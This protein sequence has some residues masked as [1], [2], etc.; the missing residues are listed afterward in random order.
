M[1]NDRI[2]TYLAIIRCTCGAC[3]LFALIGLFAIEVLA[4][5]LSLSDPAF[6]ARTNPSVPFAPTDLSGLVGWYKSGVGITLN[7]SNVSQ[8]DDSSG[9]GNHASHATAGAQPLYNAT[10]ANFNN[11]ATL[12]FDGTSDHLFANGLLSSI[13]NGTDVPFTIVMAVKPVLSGGFPTVMGTNENPSGNTQFRARFRNS[14]VN[15]FYMALRDGS[16]TD[17][18][19]SAGTPTA[20]VQIVRYQSSGTAAE[21]FSNNSSVASGS[22]NVAACSA[23]WFTFGATPTAATT[24]TNFQPMDLGEVCVYSRLLNSTEQGQIETYFR[25]KFAAY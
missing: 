20:T 2:L 18:S 13:I 8:W 25:N 7:G 14:S 12:T 23:T 16:G 22:F 6:V 5:P 9:N 3:F 24:G 11:Q 1:K 15:T 19:I 17:V 4:H 10:D 21:I